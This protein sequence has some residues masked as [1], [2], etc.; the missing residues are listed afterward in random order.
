[1]EEHLNPEDLAPAFE[2]VD[3]AHADQPVVSRRA[4][5]ASVAGVAGSI[6]LL[7]LPGVASASWFPPHHRPYW[8]KHHPV[9]PTPPPP[10]PPM[11]DGGDSPETILAVAATAEV[12]AT[13][14]NT[15]GWQK[16]VSGAITLDAV[17]KRNIAAAAREE[18]IHYNVLVGAGAVPL[19]KK[20]WVPDAVFAD[21]SGLLN[22]LQVGDQIFVNAYLL[23]TLRFAQLGNPA[24]AVTAAEFMGVEAVHRAL[25]RQSLGQL[26]NDRVFMKLD[27]VETAPG[28][29]NVGQPGFLKIMD[30]AAQLS[31]AGFGFGVQGATP[32]AFY[33]FDTVSKNTPN[34]PDLNTLT[35][36]TGS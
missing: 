1:V 15:I 20:I 6:G 12:L 16:A 11:S 33:D 8:A 19:T 18:L 26:G 4:M 10:K 7:G 14:V 23:G 32:G 9:H 24:L 35:P 28:A 2:A 5:I 36:A 21:A 3:K 27:Q 13:I 17:T 25:A 30:A 34:D 22:T 31:A 29:P